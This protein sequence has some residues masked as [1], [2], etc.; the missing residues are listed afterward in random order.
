MPP[1]CCQHHVLLI[2]CRND[3]EQVGYKPGM[4]NGEKE[5]QQSGVSADRVT[6]RWRHAWGR[7]LGNSD[8]RKDWVGF[9]QRHIGCDG[10]FSVQGS[11][12][13]A[14]SLVAGPVLSASGSGWGRFTPATPLVQ[15]LVPLLIRL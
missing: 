9:K 1:I 15:G 14:E 5:L 12:C 8:K 6:V 10:G 11:L 7:S 3:P 4:F 13:F 2:R